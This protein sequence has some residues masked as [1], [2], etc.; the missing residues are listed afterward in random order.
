VWAYD[1]WGRPSHIIRAVTR[2][3]EPEWDAGSR[4]IAEGLAEYDAGVCPDCGLHHSILDNPDEW[5]P[6]KLE[7]TVCQVGAAIARHTRALAARDRDWE[8]QH[9]EPARDQPLKVHLDAARRKHPGDGRRTRLRFMGA[10]E[11]QKA[12]QKPPTKEG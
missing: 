7:D 4:L 8:T 5:P 6:I 10:D 3:T 2:Q 1:S 12:T 9:P 11:I